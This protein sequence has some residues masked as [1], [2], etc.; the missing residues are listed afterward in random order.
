MFII[1][2]TDEA[3]KEN[4]D[5]EGIVNDYFYGKDE[6]LLS[7]NEFP[8]RWLVNEYG[9]KRYKDAERKVRKMIETDIDD[10]YLRAKSYEVIE[11]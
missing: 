3:T 9:Y 6:H 10:K 11:A 5:F 7:R 8:V 1:K 2:I 4:T